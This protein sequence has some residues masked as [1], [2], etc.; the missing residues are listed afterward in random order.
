MITTAEQV[1]PEF[2]T[3]VLRSGGFLNRGEVLNVDNKLTKKLFLSVVSRLE[4]VYSADAPDSAPSKLFL[5]IS[6]PDFSRAVAPE[7]RGREVEFYNVIAREMN[8]SPVIRCFHADYS[9]EF[10]N[11]SLLLDDLSD[12]HFQPQSPQTP[13]IMLCESAVKCLAQLHAFWWE[14]PQLGKEI[15]KLFDE[16]ELNAFVD[17]VEKN[18]IGFV[19]FLGDRLSDKQRKIYDR[20][21]VTKLKIWERLTDA[22]GLTVTHGDAHWWNVLYPHDMNKHRVCLFDWQLWHVDVGARD[23]AFMI[24]LGGYSERRKDMEQNLVR[25]YY[26]CVISHGVRNLSWEDCWNDY[27]WSAIRNLNVPVIQWSQGRSNELWQSN[28]ERAMS[29]YDDLDCAELLGN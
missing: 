25:H 12:T 14:H 27:R 18:V 5:K 11:Y 21:I 16:S 26:E 24:A 1:T 28:L 3:E 7:H 29:A 17:D 9:P 13:S 8:D 23:L 10:G 20:L 6:T 4:I 22:V 15:G 19:D 2:L